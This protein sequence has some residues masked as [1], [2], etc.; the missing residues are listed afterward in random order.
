MLLQA[1]LAIAS[2][3]SSSNETLLVNHAVVKDNH[4][5]A[6]LSVAIYAWLE[7]THMVLLVSSAAV[8]VALFHWRTLTSSYTSHAN[9][10]SRIY[11]SLPRRTTIATVAAKHACIFF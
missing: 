2:L 8:G 7:T 3:G 4:L 5:I 11:L 1:Y 9:E 6:A 10:A